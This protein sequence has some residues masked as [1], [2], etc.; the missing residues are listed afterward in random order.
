MGESD[1]KKQYPVPPSS[2]NGSG[3]NGSSSKYSGH[4]QKIHVNPPETVNPD[5]S[6]LKDQWKYATREYSKWYSHAWGTA[7]LAGLAFFALGW[8]IKGQNPLLSF[9]SD[10][11]PPPP[12]SP[13]SSSSSSSA[14]NTDEDKTRP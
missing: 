13:S 12:P 11:S 6:T 14:S 2:S 7:L 10:H 1:P 5:P 8:V 4:N 3:K 9:R